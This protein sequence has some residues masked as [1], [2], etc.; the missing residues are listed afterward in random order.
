MSIKYALST[1]LLALLLTSGCAAPRTSLAEG[2]PL[3]RVDA[4]GVAL[5]GFDPVAYIESD[6]AVRGR[7]ELALR[8][9]GAEYWF[10]SSAN[11]ARFEAVPQLYE[12]AYGGWCAW[13]MA[14]GAN[15]KGALVDVDP[16]SFLVQE[17][18]L[19]LFF[20]GVFADTRA[21]WLAGDRRG[22]ERAANEN[23]ARIVG[24]SSTAR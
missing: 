3:A 14:A 18:R 21:R 5:D 24:E 10:A 12:P 13:A 23:W 6:D 7:P 4:S 2:E 8:W 17:G 22:L 1:A 19:M 16:G 15:G 20:D 9:N 11:R